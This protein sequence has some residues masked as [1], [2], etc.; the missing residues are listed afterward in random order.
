MM[1]TRSAVSAAIS[2]AIGLGLTVVAAP[3]QAH[4]D[5]SDVLMYGKVDCIVPGTNRMKT[6]P[7]TRV[8]FQTDLGEAVD[9]TL[10]NAPPGQMATPFSYTAQFY[11]IPET[12][13]DGL[14]G[15]AYNVYTT[16]HNAPTPTWAARFRIPPR[17][18][19]HLWF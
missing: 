14:N 16:C 8:R 11:N 10:G 19:P 12:G 6:E 3:A 9:A 17:G 18:E 15:V 1:H 5:T 7:P 13:P 4:Q 2:L